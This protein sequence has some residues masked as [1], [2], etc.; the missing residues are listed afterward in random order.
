MIYICIPLEFRCLRSWVSLWHFDVARPAVDFC[1]VTA[2]KPQPRVQLGLG[3]GLD[4]GSGKCLGISFLQIISTNCLGTEYRP[5][6]HT[7][8]DHI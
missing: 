3:S 2:F 1:Q 4:L 6:I 5:D 8:V 7:H